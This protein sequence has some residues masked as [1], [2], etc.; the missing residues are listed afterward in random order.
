MGNQ[1]NQ[2]RFKR[3]LAGTPEFDHV[4]HYLNSQISKLYG[5]QQ[6]AIRKIAEGKDRNCELLINKSAKEYGILIY[7]NQ[8]TS[9]INNL[10]FP[11]TFVIKTLFVINPLENSGKRV[12]TRLLNHSSQIASKLHAEHLFV[13]VSS[14]RPESI[15]FFLNYGF[16]I[17]SV[18]QDL[19]LKGLNEYFLFHHEPAKLLSNTSNELSVQ[20]KQRSPLS[21]YKKKFNESTL[22]N[23][24]ALIIGAFASHKNPLDFFYDY[25]GFSAT[26][27]IIQSS[28]KKFAKLTLNWQQ[29]K[30]AKHYLVIFISP[31]YQTPDRTHLL[32]DLMIGVTLYGKRHVLGFCPS[33]FFPMIYWSEVFNEL[34]AIGIQEIDILCC[35][36]PQ[37]ISMAIKAIF[38]LTKIEKATCP[39]PWFSANLSPKSLFDE[40]ISNLA[41]PIH[42]FGKAKKDRILLS[43]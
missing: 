39:K 33:R 12:A 41:Y 32:G 14:R 1:S 10:S 11:G 31:L 20:K 15:A 22:T 38:P 8:L 3:V 27:D 19:Y 30:M 35:P 2:I 42:A 9:Q 25:Y 18:Y 23:M 13:S 29:R 5:N 21:L 37:N 6:S 7:K 17:E 40:M 28:M 4:K 34:K 36:Q 26:D 24:E 16:R 43:P